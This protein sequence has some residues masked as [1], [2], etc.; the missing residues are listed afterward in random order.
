MLDAEGDM[1]ITPAGIDKGSLTPDD[2]ICVSPM[3][4]S[5]SS[6]ASSEYPSIAP[7]ITATDFRAIVHAHHPD[8]SPSHRA[9]DPQ[10]QDHP[11][12]HYVCGT[13]G[14]A[15]YALPGSQQLGDI[16]A[17]TFA[18]GVDIVLLENHGVVAG[19]D[20]LLA[21]FQRFE[22]LDFCARTLIRASTVGEVRSLTDEEIA[23]SGERGEK[24]PKFTPKSHTTGEL[25]LRTKIVDIV[26]R[27]YEQRLMTS[28]EGT[29]SARVDADSFL[30]T[31]FGVD[32]KYLDIEDL[33]LIRKGH[34]ERRKSP[35]ARS[36]SI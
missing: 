7:S 25:N 34:R 3:G 35:A 28:T 24:L 21:A 1:W 8:S 4:E 2:I 19:A 10:H 20:S 30:I 36:D 26:H 9:Q 18:E 29:V 5:S 16:I 31:P 6:H 11:Q 14:Y 27:A 17:A 12:A 22:T 15:P 32:R 23:L 33:V 13:V